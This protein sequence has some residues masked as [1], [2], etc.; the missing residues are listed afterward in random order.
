MTVKTVKIDTC[1]DCPFMIWDG[2]LCGLSR[3]SP[4]A[5]LRGEEGEA[6]EEAAEEAA[7]VLPCRG[8]VIPSW[9]PLP[10]APEGSLSDRSERI[11]EDR[12]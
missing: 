8:C 7:K 9:C 1:R 3:V 12:L 11:E 4:A 5:D 10:S 6:A 2:Y